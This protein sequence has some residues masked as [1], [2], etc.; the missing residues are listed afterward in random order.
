M[1]WRKPIQ[2]A[3]DGLPSLLNFIYLSGLVLGERIVVEPAA[4]RIYIDVVVPT[5]EVIVGGRQYHRQYGG[6]I[7]EKL[8]ELGVNSGAF[9]RIAFLNASLDQ[10][11]QTAW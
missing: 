9:G 5:L 3:L 10:E 7:V 4:K 8:V 11:D 2:L 6:L 1:G